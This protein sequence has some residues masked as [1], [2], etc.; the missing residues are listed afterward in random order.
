M[1]DLHAHSSDFVQRISKRF[2]AFILS[3]VEVKM[4]HAMTMLFFS[5][6]LDKVSLSVIV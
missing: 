6:T 2:C 3:Y 5:N 1:H 4:R